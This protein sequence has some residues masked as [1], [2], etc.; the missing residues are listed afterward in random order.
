MIISV[1]QAQLFL[2]ALTRILAI[3]VQIPVLGGSLIPTQVRIAFGIVL[4]VV[5]T[6]WTVQ[7]PATATELPLLGLVSALFNELIIG[8]LAGFAASLTFNAL[9][10]AGEMIT[11]SSGFGSGRVLN[12]LLEQSGS[13]LDQFFVYIAI[14]IFMTI[15]GHHTVIMAIQRTFAVLPIN[16]PLPDFTANRMLMLVGQMIATGIQIALPVVAALLLADITLG[17]LARVSPQIQ[18]FFLGLPLKIGLALIAVGLVFVVAMPVFED[19]FNNL[20][21]RMLRLLGA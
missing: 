14:L 3:I 8:I 16:Q 10:I 6:P 13:A 19:L 9:Q 20:G 7:L 17:L 15:N 2:L 5:I 1:A 12:P 18:V 4:A 21:E 11:Q